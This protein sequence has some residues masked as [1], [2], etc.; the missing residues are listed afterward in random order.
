VRWCAH[1]AAL[2]SSNVIYG[3][4]TGKMSRGAH[5]SLVL[6]SWYLVHLNEPPQSFWSGKTVQNRMAEALLPWSSE[7]QAGSPRGVW[8]KRDCFT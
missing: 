4:L 2:A 6:W 3:E 8:M 7:N 5:G 1:K